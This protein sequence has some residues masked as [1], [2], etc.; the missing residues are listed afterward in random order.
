MTY[1]ICN[2]CEADLS[3]SCAMTRANF[4]HEQLKVTGAVR[5]DCHQCGATVLERQLKF[6][7][8]AT[9]ILKGKK[10]LRILHFNPEPHLVDYLATLQPE[11]HIL[12][13]SN[14]RDRR[15]ETVNIEKLPYDDEVFDLIIANRQLEAVISIDNALCELNRVLK[16]DGH[17]VM[18]TT[19]SLVLKT[20][21]E[22]EGISK[23]NVQGHIYGAAHHRRLFG[24]DV[25]HR[26]GRIFNNNAPKFVQPT[27]TD[28]PH[29]LDVYEPFMLFTKKTCKEKVEFAPARVTLNDDV[30]VSILCITYNHAAFIGNALNSFV[31]QKTN[32]RFEIVIGEDCSTDNTLEILKSWENNYPMKIKILPPL[33]NMGIH[34]NLRRTYAACTGRYIAYCEGDDRWT[35][36]LKLQKQFDYLESHPECVL[37]YGNAQAHKNGSIDYN[38]IGGAKVDLSP[39]ILQ[40][41]PPI[42]TLSVMFRKAFLQL[43]PEQ[44]ACGA[45]D[46]FIWSMLGQLGSGHYMP[47]I[48]PSIYNMHAGGVHALTGVANQHRLRLKTFY[49]AFHYYARNGNADLANYFLQGVAKDAAY[50]AQIS[51]VAQAK[52]MLEPLVSE[53]TQAMHDVF[54]LNT[55][56]LNAII[57]HVLEQL[58]PIH[59]D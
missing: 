53:M 45:G 34:L 6:Y 29:K 56:A 54:P 30:A 21:W 24:Q 27:S 2:Y 20:T 1:S 50:I 36:P 7:F 46:M 58:E 19:F 33:P 16:S 59:G 18:Q 39:H 42:N 51:T 14:D 43:P 38:Y 40:H 28:N 49:A 17:L 48:L 26:I 35:D 23:S 37:V 47:S 32:F 3:E 5:S 13:V 44:L 9:E 31:N 52:A 8:D 55:F 10:S 11:F 25:L 22:D 57:N 41:A 4:W 15:Y 12:A